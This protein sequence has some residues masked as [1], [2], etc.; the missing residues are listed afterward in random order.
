MGK[1]RGGR[2]WP[3]AAGPI[4]SLPEGGLARSGFRRILTVPL[5][6]GGGPWVYKSSRLVAW[7]YGSGE[8]KPAVQCAGFLD[9]QDRA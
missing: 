9:G 7:S 4:A 3:E 5:A 2:A 8:K 6:E 1:G